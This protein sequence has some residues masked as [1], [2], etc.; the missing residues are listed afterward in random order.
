LNS[1]HVYKRHSFISKDERVPIPTV[2]TKRDAIYSMGEP[3]DEEA[4]ST[5]TFSPESDTIAINPDTE[6]ILDE[7]F[8]HSGRD[9]NGTSSEDTEHR[10][11]ARKHIKKQSLNNAE[12]NKDKTEYVLVKDTLAV[13]YKKELEALTQSAV[14]HA[15]FD[16]LNKKKNELKDCI[17]SA[18]RILDELIQKHEEYMAQ[19]TNELKYMAIE[20]AE[21]MILEKISIDDAILKKLVLKNIKSVKNAEWINCELS[22]RLVGL[23]DLINKELEMPEYK[24]KTSVVADADADD[25][26]RITTGAGTIISTITVQADNLRKAFTEADKE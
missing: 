24:G 8:I 22:E 15:Y 25:T 3:K 16:A 12:E 19:Y 11:Q 14:E 5:D 2:N 6:G 10:T 23:V 13:I 9:I 1:A 18:Q 4:I 7:D 26:C 21:K 17:S 20:I